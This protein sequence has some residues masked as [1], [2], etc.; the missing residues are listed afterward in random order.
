MRLSI[1]FSIRYMASPAKALGEVEDLA[2]DSRDESQR[3]AAADLGVERG[4][5]LSGL[6]GR[7]R[8]L[9][10]RIQAMGR[11]VEAARE[12]IRGTDSDPAKRHG[13]WIGTRPAAGA[14][15]RPRTSS[16]M[17]KLFEAKLTELEVS[18]EQLP[19]LTPF[20]PVPPCRWR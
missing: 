14:I 3:G 8:E 7:Y 20:A 12:S 11:R 15:R 19:R 13:S 4:R 10:S 16:R 17:R 9:E 18:R 1:A 2:C 6:L 5:E